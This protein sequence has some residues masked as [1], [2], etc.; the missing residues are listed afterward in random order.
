ML[1]VLFACVP[2][3]E[4]KP[5]N[6]VQLLPDTALDSQSSDDSAASSLRFSV[7]VWPVI[8]AKCQ[9]CHYSQYEG[10]DFPDMQTGYAKLVDVPAGQLPTMKRVE[11]GSLENS[12][13]WYKLEDTQLTVG[14]DGTQMPSVYGEPL[15]NA[16]KAIFRD[17]IVGGA[18]E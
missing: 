3:E 13:L 2:A 8:Q 15:T 7:D 18:V 17:W 1:F 10:L 11:A 6:D 9:G 16:E 5:S 12:Y 4:S 14:G